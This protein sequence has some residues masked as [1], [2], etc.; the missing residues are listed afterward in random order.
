MLL[1]STFKDT[2]MSDL[3]SLSSKLF[4]CVDKD[5]AKKSI[6]RDQTSDDASSIEVDA[7]S[8][9]LKRTINGHASLRR[10]LFDISR[11][12]STSQKLKSVL[13]R[14]PNHSAVILMSPRA[15][16]GECS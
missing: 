10:N 4:L 13:F 7:P 5:A 16:P 12:L 3:H 14:Q 11:H 15:C 9:S 2:I 1:S 6:E 8:P